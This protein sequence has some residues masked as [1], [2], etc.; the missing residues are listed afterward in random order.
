MA[1]VDDGD[2]ENLGDD[3][4]TL[5]VKISRKLLARLD[6]RI[7]DPVR[8][9]PSYGARSKIIRELISRHCTEK[10]TE[11]ER[12]ADARDPRALP[13]QPGND[14]PAAAN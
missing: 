10:E 6:S 5:K 1:E 3:P 9:K 8:N 11:D 4:V 2:S 14:D 13:T 7:F 12:N